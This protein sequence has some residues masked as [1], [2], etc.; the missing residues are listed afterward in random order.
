MSADNLEQLVQ[1]AD[2]DGLVRHVDNTVADRD[3]DHLVRIRN[4]SRSA[5]DTGRQLWPIATLANVRLALWAPAEYAVQSLDDHVRTFMPGPVSEILAVHHTWDELA[6]LLANG[7]D[8][9]L[10]AYERALRGDSVD[11]DEHGVLDIPILPCDW[12]P[13][14]VVATY[15]DDGGEFPTPSMPDRGDAVDDTDDFIV[16][17]DVDVQSA[18][19]QLMEPWTAQSNGQASCIMTQGGPSQALR[20][21]GVR[22][23]ELEPLTPPEALAWLAWAG[24]SGGAHGK[25]RG[26]ASG[27]FGAWWTLAAI[28]GMSEDW[29][30]DPDEFGE[31][32][33]QM[34]FWWWDDD[35]AR[36]GWE[37]RIVIEDP[38]E[39][40]S[41]ALRAAD[42]ETEK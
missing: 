39:E 22:D 35:E 29:P 25:R 13:R 37:L 36:S 18:F 19:R 31:I 14:Y 10:Y 38:E 7:H 3:W 20:A 26:A 34:N 6:P 11:I 30:L 40:I 24:A 1:R 8:R 2:L 5:V 15:T 21:L 23:A 12:E 42:A 4:A 9:S 16:L 32:V 27:R 33:S 28:S 41:C 17:D